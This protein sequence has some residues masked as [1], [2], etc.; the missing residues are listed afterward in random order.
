MGV[1]IIMTA[2]EIKIRIKAIEEAVAIGDHEDAHA[3]EDILREKFLEYIAMLEYENKEG[4]QLLDIVGKAAL[5]LT[6]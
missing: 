4:D 6:A 1:V 3:H 2:E 5:V